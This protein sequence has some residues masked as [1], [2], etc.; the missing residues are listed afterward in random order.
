MV[1]ASLSSNSTFRVSMV[2]WPPV[3]MAS[4]ALTARFMM[5]CSNCPWFALTGDRVGA[6]LGGEVDV[7]SDDPPQHQIKISQDR[8]EVQLL[9]DKD[10]LPAEGQELARQRPRPVHPPSSSRGPTGVSG[11]SWAGLEAPAPVTVDEAKEVI[12]VVGHAASQTDHHFHFLGLAGL[13]FQTEAFRDVEGDAANQRLPVPPG[14]G[15][16]LTS[17]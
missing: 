16:L 5:T 12:E 14:M 7:L 1:L 13:L 17:E 4:R 11:C 3:G 10:L 15:N 6:K 9:R 8:V 2:N